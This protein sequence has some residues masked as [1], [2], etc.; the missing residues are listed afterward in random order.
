M[1]EQTRPDAPRTIAEALH[2]AV[3]DG[4]A[5]LA[6]AE[7][8]YHF[9][10]GTWHSARCDAPEKF[11][12]E[13]WEKRARADAVCAVCAAGAVIARS[14]GAGADTDIGPLAVPPRWRKALYA[15]DATRGFRWERA[16]G[17]MHGERRDTD[18]DPARRFAERVDAALHDSGPE[19]Y[20][21]TW[22][23]GVF[24]GDQ[25]FSDYLDCVEAVV[26]PAI[27]RSEGEGLGEHASGVET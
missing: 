18:I 10:A 3:A 14:L 26:L 12:N 2:I 7:A 5:L 17:A 13:R 9:D 27:E 4:R 16:W 21:R 8:R 23:A 11:D 6:D 22:K 19:A 1:T 24:E 20:E 15:I 25:A